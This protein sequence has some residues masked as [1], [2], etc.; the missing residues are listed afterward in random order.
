M[1]NDKELEPGYHFEEEGDDKL[2][3]WWNEEG[4]DEEDEEGEDEL[5]EPEDE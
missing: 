5:K 1:T 4:F 2:L 3:E